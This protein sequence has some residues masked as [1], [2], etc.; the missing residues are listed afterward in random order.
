[1]NI[2]VG[3][4]GQVGSAIVKELNHKNLP[5]RAVIRNAERLPEKGLDMRIADLFSS[6]QL[7]DAFDGGT[8]VFLLTPENPMS[9][10]IIG[11][12]KQITDNYRK[13]IQMTGIR[14]IVGL[15]FV[16]AH[17][18]GNTGNILMSEIL[19]QTFDDLDVEK[20]FIR[21]SYYYSNWLGY[22][23]TIEQFSVL[24]TFF[25]KDLKIDMNSPIDVAKFVADVI[26]RSTSSEDKKIFEL[27]GP[28]KYS[29]FE[30]AENFSHLLSKNIE[31]QPVPK[32]KW[33]ETL[34]S[35]GFTKNTSSNL[36]DMTE[37]VIE[38]IAK[39]ESEDKAIKLQTSLYEYLEEQLK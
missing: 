3:A 31:T 17:I 37:A 2:I 4:S 7:I 5:V 6:D 33:H 22:L 18:K 36:S 10:D 32:K 28:Q 27:V 9:N 26:I 24:P 19:E 12:T 23:D 11:E 38:G 30:V 15:S 8:T 39:P 16:G 21:P 20:I 35:V 29:S 14:K 13:A 25:P 34:I 1:M